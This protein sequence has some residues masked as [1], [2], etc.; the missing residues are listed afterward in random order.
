MVIDPEPDAS[1]V[2]HDAALETQASIEP[3]GAVNDGPLEHRLDVLVALDARRPDDEAAFLG[4]QQ[5]A[6]A[7]VGH[8][9]GHLGGVERHGDVTPRTAVP[10]RDRAGAVLE[11]HPDVAVAVAGRPVGRQLELLPEADVGRRRPW[12]LARPE[13]VDRPAA[14][15]VDASLAALEQMSGP[16]AAQALLPAEAMQLAV[17]VA[18]DAAVGQPEPQRA[19]G[20]AE[21]RM[22]IQ[23][24]AA[25]VPLEPRRRGEPLDPALGRDA[26]EHA[27]LG[28]G[29][30]RVDKQGAVADAEEAVGLPVVEGG[31]DGRREDGREGSEVVDAD[32]L[33]AGGQSQ[34]PVLAPQGA[35]R[36]PLLGQHGRGEAALG[37]AAVEGV[38]AALAVEVH[39]LAGVEDRCPAPAQARL[40]ALPLP[41]RPGREEALAPVEDRPRPRHM[42]A[43]V[44]VG[45]RVLEVG[46]VACV[47][48]GEPVELALVLLVAALGEAERT[49]AAAVEAREV[50][51]RCGQFRAARRRE[52]LAVPAI[53]RAVGHHPQ[54]A[55]G[56]DAHVG[57]AARGGR[58]QRQL[59]PSAARLG[60]AANPKSQAPDHK[61]APSPKSR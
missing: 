43:G 18:D 54:R 61:Q 5:Q 12:R 28:L 37:Q 16:A 55:V 4:E 15:R 20:R 35:E 6:P 58:R 49:V 10:A 57:E 14:R 23:R 30:V 32:T 25:R 11:E 47:A 2:E 33:A 27:A 39:G 3:R 26:A 31:Q 17:L 50:V 36:R 40:D 13:D 8:A 46:H 21:H 51:G 22:R 60:G 34:H 41:T 19:V 29:I 52:A 24:R 38:E 59:V 1:A 53:D 56:L 7:V 42:Q 9:V 45:H 44:A 48:V